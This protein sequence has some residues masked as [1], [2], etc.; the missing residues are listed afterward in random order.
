MNSRLSEVITVDKDKCVSCHACI[1]ACPVKYCNDGSSDVVSVNSDMCIACGNCIKVCTHEARSFE[2]NSAA[3]FKD[4]G[5]VP[6]VAVIAPAVAAN[7]PNQYLRLNGW[8][9]RSGISAAFDVS[10]GA[11]LTVKSYLEHIKANKPK[12]VIAQPCPAIVTYIEIY[13]PELLDFLAP[14]DS[15]MLHTVK[16]IKEFYPQY[17]NHRVAVIS[18]CIAKRREFEETGYGDYNVTFQSI[19][20]YLQD[21]HIS[22]AS[23]ND[24]D[25][26]NP[27]AERAVLFS[28]PGGLL[29]TA[30][31]EVPDAASFSRKIEGQPLIYHYLKQLPEALR[32]GINPLL[33]DCLNCEMG[34]NG[35]TGTNS[36]DKSLDEVEYL[37]E[38]RNI[39]MKKVYKE[40]GIPLIKNKSTLT[41]IIEKYWKPGLYSRSYKN[42]SALNNIRYPHDHELTEVYKKLNKFSD[43]DM[44]NCGACGYGTCLGMATAL[45]NNLNKPENCLHNQFALLNQHNINVSEAVKKLTDMVKAIAGRSTIIASNSANVAVTA[46]QLSSSV[47]SVSMSVTDVQG[48]MSSIYKAI[49]GLTET[50][51]EIAKQSEKTR[52]VTSTAVENVR[53]IETKVDQ[54]GAASA[55]ISSVIDTII[56]IAEQTKLLA[57]NATIEAARAGDAGKGFAVVASEVKELARQ[58]NLA[59]VEIKEK[60]TNIA[61]STGATIDGI[62]NIGSVI[63]NINQFVNTIAAAVEEQSITARDITDNVS[64]NAKG[65]DSIAQNVTDSANGTQLIA[66]NISEVNTQIAEVADAVEMLNVQAGKLN[67]LT[68]G[69]N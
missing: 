19:Q 28:T 7:F 1:T 34:C 4:L 49:D 12:M 55:S 10:F 35:G 60:I 42:L 23:F 59:T 67:D 51:Q 30:E 68:E 36:Y 52:L 13:Q 69:E 16:M 3:F 48:V 26:D 25:Y 61:Q 6:M 15:P 21:N 2:D 63:N 65:I 31:R 17:R 41:Q 39:A 20:K 33:I 14:A 57:L 56:E 46:Q 66:S 47:N 18:P 43:S 32:A 54:L 38:Q 29:R 37:V 44:Y 9:K 50:I 8:L 53:S 5:N 40:K 22:L 45:F 62:K 27:P 11:E 64:R 58:T 24:V